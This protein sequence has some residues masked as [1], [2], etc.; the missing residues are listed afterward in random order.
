[1]QADICR[2][3]YVHARDSTCVTIYMYVPCRY[4]LFD[5]SKGRKS[6]RCYVTRSVHIHVNAH[7]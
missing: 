3:M 6:L 4:K 1:M 2:Y 5:V 7:T